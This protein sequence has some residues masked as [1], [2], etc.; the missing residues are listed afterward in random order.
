[1][2]GSVP[3]N[4]IPAVEKGLR[5]A[6]K[7][8]ILA[9][10]PVVDFKAALYY[11]SYHPVDSSDLAFQLAAVLAFKKVSELAGPMLLE[12]VMTASVTVPEE[13]MGQ[14]IGDLNSKR[15]RVLGMDSEAGFSTV[16]AEVPQAEMQRY[17]TDIR[18]MTQG[19]GI[20][21]ME[22]ARYEEIPSHLVQAIVDQA[23]KDREE[24]REAK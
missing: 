13:Y 10:F 20:F 2:G 9:G 5:E 3:R 4:Y 11:G 24:A 16:S 18:S 7:T 21:T 17:A 6:L 12:P 22:F 1:V 23:K 8:G 15:G 14:V 19:R